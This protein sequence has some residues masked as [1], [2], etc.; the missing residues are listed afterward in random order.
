MPWAKLDDGFYDHPKFTE[1]LEEPDGWAALGF[2]A[3]MLAWANRHTRKPGKIPGLL[4]RLDV[5]RMDRTRGP[6]FAGVLVKVGLWEIHADGWLIHDFAQYLPKTSTSEARAE[7]GRKGGI[8]SGTSRSLKAEARSFDAEASSLEGEANAKQ[9]VEANAG[10]GIGSSTTAEVVEG[11]VVARSKDQ[12]A[13]RLPDDFRVTAEMVAWARKDVPNVDGRVETEKFR[14]HW[15][16]ASGA[17]ARKKDWVA[18]WRNWM[19]NADER[20]GRSGTGYRAADKP[21]TLDEGFW[22][23]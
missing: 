22:E 21:G 13:C 7:A 15:K 18:A 17:T 4:K 2:W 1:L 19:R 6:V 8:A 12:N 3:A 5:A 9:G 20:L 23:R 16:A 11:S 14:D 10:L